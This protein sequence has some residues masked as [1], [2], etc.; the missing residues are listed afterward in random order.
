MSAAIA[1][2]AR[3]CRTCCSSTTLP[4]TSSRA[5]LANSRTSVATWSLRLR[6][7]WSLAPAGPAAQGL[8]RRPGLDAETPEPHEALGVVV[9]EAVGGLVGRQP[10]VVE[11][12][13]APP[14]H[15]EAATGHLAAKPHLAGDEALAL[16]DE[17][18][19]RLLQRREPETVVHEVGVARLEAR[20]L[21]GQVTFEGDVL[22]IGVRHQERERTGALV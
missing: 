18:V 19:E 2:L 11:S 13:L 6:P 5:R 16:V 8:A 14:P 4:A 12:H 1:A 17:R 9:A 20:L 3:S 15:C 7:V 22:E 21:V 10:V